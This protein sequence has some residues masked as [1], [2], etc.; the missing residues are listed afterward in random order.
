[1]REFNLQKYLENPNQKIVTREGKSV[2]IICTDRKD[3]L[4]D[5]GPIVALV[6][7]E[8]KGQELSCFYYPDGRYYK[9]ETY[10]LDLFFAPT[11][12]EGWINMYCN[13]GDLYFSN[14]IYNNEQDAKKKAKGSPY[15][16]ATTK[17]E[18][19]D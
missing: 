6:Y 13:S 9:E 17:I 4:A 3:D 19:E 18:W 15:Y 11:K 10:Y 2:R 1:M 14:V 7:D 12:H 16:V 5:E 8:T